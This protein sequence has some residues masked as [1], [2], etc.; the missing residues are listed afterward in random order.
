MIIKTILLIYLLLAAT[1]ANCQNKTALGS[2]D[3]F[4]S[5][6]DAFRYDL[7]K[8]LE[9]KEYHEAYL[10]LM[11]MDTTTAIYSKSKQFYLTHKSALEA[12]QL[13]LLEKHTKTPVDFTNFVKD[14][15][16]NSEQDFLKETLLHPYLL[17][18]LLADPFTYTASLVDFAYITTKVNENVERR[19]T[20]NELAKP[21]VRAERIDQNNWKITWDEYYY[22]YILSYN[23]AEH[24]LD[25]HEVYKRK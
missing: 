10:F 2:H 21:R 8:E 18:L 22:I 3:T 25:L 6:L 13:S 16:F 7:Y 23:L 11:M 12:Y 19:N 15:S 5:K 1:I 4:V 14:T 20:M 17:R 24:N 9:G